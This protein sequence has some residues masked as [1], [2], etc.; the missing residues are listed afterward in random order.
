MRGS[1][2]PVVKGLRDRGILAIK[3]G[4]KVLRLLPPLTVGSADVKRLLSELEVVL[5]EGAVVAA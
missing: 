4:E 1:A 2:G 5:K 3:A